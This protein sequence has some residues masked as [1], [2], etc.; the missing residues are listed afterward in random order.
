M[1][2]YARPLLFIE[3]RDCFSLLW[4]LWE[5]VRERRKGGEVNK[6]EVTIVNGS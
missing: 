4:A 5:K 6:N 1:A 2:A 3:A